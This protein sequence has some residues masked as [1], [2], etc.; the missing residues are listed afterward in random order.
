MLNIGFFASS[1]NS[2]KD[3]YYN[4]VNELLRS[5]KNIKRINKAV[6]GGGNTGI[7]GM[8]HDVFKDNII[9]HNLEKW[10]VYD[11]ENIHPDI[12]NRQRGILESSDVFIV[13]P[14]GVGTISELFDCIMM[15]D[16]NSFSKNKPI[17]IYDCDNYYSE[18]YKFI[19]N[20][21]QTGASKKCDSLFISSDVNMIVSIIEKI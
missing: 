20:L 5:I 1:K 2:L 6:Y 9:S 16:T 11:D 17:I 7:M 21:Y 14:G 12:L 10:K 15:N 13:L 4:Q 8:V 19:E 3:K 18:L